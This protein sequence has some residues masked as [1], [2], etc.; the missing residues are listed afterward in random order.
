[1]KARAAPFFSIYV[2]MSGALLVGLRGGWCTLLAPLVTTFVLVPIFDAVIGV[3]ARDPPDQPPGRA[4]RAAFRA[5]IWLAAPVQAALLLWGASVVVQPSSALVEKVGATVSVGLVGGVLG[6][7][8]AHELIHRRSRIDRAFGAIILA[9]VS[10]LHWMIEHLAG[11]HRRVATPN[12]PAT[13][14]LGEPLPAF[15]ARS[16]AGGYRSSWSIEAAR[17]ERARPG[18]G[19][20]ALRNRVLW[21]T[22]APF[23]LA[24]ALAAVFGPAAAVFFFAQS[25]IAVLLLETVNYIE[26]YG[27][28]RRLVGPGVYERVTPIHSW[29]ASHRMTNWLLFNLQ[30]HSDHHVSPARAYYELRQFD[31]SPQLPFGYAGMALLAFVPPLWRRVMDPRVAAHRARLATVVPGPPAT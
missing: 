31:A 24:A 6:I 2:V 12:D 26:H 29:N 21:L 7:T 1:M 11:H 14:R 4:A 17:L 10:Y 13:A 22:V 23:V 3:D 27:L 16:V 25:L 5:A 20:P 15:V 9:M 28:E 19:A 8:A 18:A 30:R